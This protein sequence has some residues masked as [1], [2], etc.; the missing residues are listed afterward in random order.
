MTFNARETGARTGR[1]VFLYTWQRGE[2][3]WRYTGADQ[4]LQIQFQDYISSPIDHDEIEQ[5]PDMARLTLPVRVPM[6]HPVALMYRAQSPV[7]SVVVTISEFHAGDPDQEVRPVWSGRIVSVG[8][9]IPENEATINHSPTYTSMA[10]TG[11]RRRCQ[12]NCPL[13][14]FGLACGANREAFKLVTTVGALTG[15]N[16]TA[17]GVGA[18]FDGYW[19]GGYIE[20]LLQPGVF[21]RR[22]ISSHTGGT[23]ALTGLP[24]GLTQGQA[25]NIYPG[26]DHTTGANGCAKF[27]NIPRYGGFPYFARK[28]PFGNEPV[29]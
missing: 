7:D 3:V 5:G 14:L 27:N 21:E 28:N 10:R 4:N 18:H 26:C 9:D 2:R 13:V 23:L 6:L 19:N 25:V 29:Y 22:S 1:K 17:A 12:L 8:W 16:L 15:L 11:L 24:V 20:Y